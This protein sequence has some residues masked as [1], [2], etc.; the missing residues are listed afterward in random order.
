MDCPVSLSTASGRIRA[1]TRFLAPLWEKANPRLASSGPTTTRK[2][3]AP[4]A[5]G[6]GGV[7]SV[8][9]ASLTQLRRT[10][11]D[12][13]GATQKYVCEACEERHDTRWDA[14][15]C[16]KPKVKEV[17]VCEECDEEHQTAQGA[18]E[19]CITV[20]SGEDLRIRPLQLEAHG[21]KK[22]F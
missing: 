5:A 2:I 19:C 8:E 9:T 18:E 16:C 11:S 6:S 12:V 20:K 14:E 22:L 10:V 1:F 7:R 15:E 17:W 4:Q 13:S 21:Q 3:L